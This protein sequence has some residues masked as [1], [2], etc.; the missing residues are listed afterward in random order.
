MFAIVFIV[1][2]SSYLTRELFPRKIIY[3]PSISVSPII[4]EGAPVNVKHSFEGTEVFDLL[5]EKDGLI[6][7]LRGELSDLGHK[8]TELQDRPPDTV[9]IYE[10][11]IPSSSI[12][13]GILH[14][15]IRNG[16]F[17]ADLVD[18]SDSTAKFVSWKRDDVKKDFEIWAMQDPGLPVDKWIRLNEKRNIFDLILLS[19]GYS[20]RDGPFI[21]FTKFRVWKL[22]GKG[23]GL[24]GE[25]HGEAWIDWMR[26]L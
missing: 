11:E 17:S 25:I 3:K 4:R 14:L 12:K 23:R 6:D 22:H 1:A 8:F 20:T 19:P 26:V 24:E 21:D 15:R 13:R 9:I 18:L 5:E 10:A 2:I 7:R 16:L